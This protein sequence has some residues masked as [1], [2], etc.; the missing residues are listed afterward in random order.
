MESASD[1]SAVFLHCSDNETKE[2][3]P[4]DYELRVI[5]TLVGKSLKIDYSVKN[6]GKGNMY[7]N[8]G[9]HEGYATPEGI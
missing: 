2:V 3:Y 8:I 1:T 9:G 7:F 6:T 4:F 5:F